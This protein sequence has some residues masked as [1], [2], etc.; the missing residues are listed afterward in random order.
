MLRLKPEIM[1][2]ET[3]FLKIPRALPKASASSPSSILSESPSLTVG[4]SAMDFLRFVIFNI[5]T[6][7]IGSIA[8]ISALNRFP[9][10]VIT[11]YSAPESATICLLVRIMP[12]LS[13]INPEPLPTS[14]LPAPPVFFFNLS[15]F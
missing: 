3:V 6:S 15:L 14:M 8:I 7:F 4:N 12:F 13:T 11:V 5:A 1:P 2:S 10:V 9:S